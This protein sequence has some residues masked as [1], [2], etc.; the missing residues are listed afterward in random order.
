MG[1]APL[2]DYA[3]RERRRPAAPHGRPLGL[4]AVSHRRR[5]GWVAVVAAHV[6]ASYAVVT[7]GIVMDAL[8]GDAPPVVHGVLLWMSSP[9]VAPI[10]LVSQYTVASAPQQLVWLTGYVIIFSAT[11]HRV[12][13]TARRRA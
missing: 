11:F 9:V 8:A 10:S 6:A 7:A 13:R 4:R 3:T 1:D 2:L 12:R 5:R